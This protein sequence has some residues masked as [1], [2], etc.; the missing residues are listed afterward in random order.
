SR[1][2]CV[3]TKLDPKLTGNWQLVLASRLED[4][5]VELD[6]LA[7]GPLPGKISLH[8]V[9]SHMLEQEWILIKHQGLAD[10]FGQSSHRIFAELDAVGFLLVFRQV[11]DGV[12]QT[13]SDSDDGDGAVALAVH[14]VEATGLEARGHQEEI[15]GRFDAVR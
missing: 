6:V 13:T 8:R 3:A 1:N 12:I 7:A 2:T 10:G 9:A 11:G 5:L 14:L 4:A 15:A